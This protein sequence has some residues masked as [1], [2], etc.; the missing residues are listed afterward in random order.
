[1]AD[2]D[3]CLTLKTSAAAIRGSS[4]VKLSSL[5][6]A[7]STSVLPTSFFRYFSENIHV[8]SDIFVPQEL[9]RSALLYLFRRNRKNADN[10]DHY[11]RDCIY[12]FSSRWHLGV[13]FETSKKC[14]YAFED[15]NKIVLA[16]TNIFGY[17]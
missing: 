6:N 4:C 17:L 12:H 5:F 1:M 13:E 16:C 10:L 9:T 8:N 2:C 11:R 15:V 14:F 3:C 7:S